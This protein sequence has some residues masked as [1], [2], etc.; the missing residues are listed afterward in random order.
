[1]TRS[2]SELYL[3]FKIV[4]SQFDIIKHFSKNS[5]KNNLYNNVILTQQFCLFH[6]NEFCEAFVTEIT[7]MS[8]SDIIESIKII[9]TIISDKKDQAFIAEIIINNADIM[10]N[11]TDE[12]SMEQ[13]DMIFANIYNNTYIAESTYNT[14][15]DKIV[16]KKISYSDIE[17]VWKICSKYDNKMFC[18]I[19][20]KI[21]L[22]T[23]DVI[24]DKKMYITKWFLAGVEI[25]LSPNISGNSSNI[26]KMEHKISMFLKRNVK[27]GKN[28]TESIQNISLIV[29]ELCNVKHQGFINNV[30]KAFQQLF[31]DDFMKTFVEV[32][33]SELAASDY[34]QMSM[35]NIIE[36]FKVNGL[37]GSFVN[38]LST[39]IRN[40]YNNKFKF[41][42][43]LYNLFNEIKYSISEFDDSFA[44]LLNDIETEG[45]NTREIHTCTGIGNSKMQYVNLSY[46]YDEDCQESTTPIL[47][48]DIEEYINSVKSFHK[49]KNELKCYFLNI[50][51]T[52]IDLT[53]SDVQLSCSL[54]EASI[55]LSIRDAQGK[56]NPDECMYDSETVQRTVNMLKSKNLISVNKKTKL[57]RLK[58]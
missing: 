23:F 51:N 33:V 35:K 8:F 46:K 41:S 52:S 9:N 17:K 44:V 12:I 11:K 55:I 34:K 50:S 45:S 30:K 10:L 26:E 43:N 2:I 20:E 28:I 32:C 24:F 57:I 22:P 16:S 18:N 19:F 48:P 21:I 54:T 7:K 3:D 49:K 31:I 53:V 13:L 37:I 39:V 6:K 58:N 15:T 14:F 4:D 27:H 56:F 36:T 5:F 1:M 38:E 25:I 29:S 47:H 42:N 40:M